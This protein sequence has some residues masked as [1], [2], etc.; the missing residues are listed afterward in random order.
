LIVDQFS[1]WPDVTLYED[2]NTTANRLVN[3]CRPLFET[4]GAPEGFWSDNQP[5][6]AAFFQ[7]SLAKFNVS[8][9]SSSP[10]YPKSNGRAEAEIKQIKKLVCGSKTDGRVDPDKMAKALMLFRNAP[11]CGGGPSPAESVFNR[12]IRN[13]LPSR[14][15]SFTNEWQREPEELERRMTASREKSR[16]F[17]DAN[18][19]T[20]AALKV[21]DHVLIQDPDTSRW[22]IPGKVIEHHNT[23]SP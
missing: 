9:H 5:F 23:V 19:H 22:S 6:K 15:R 14:H 2:K 8:W 20:L 16:E 3:S 18:A 11:R 1:G 21:D 17:Y 12:P 4:M 7:D 13:G 10:H